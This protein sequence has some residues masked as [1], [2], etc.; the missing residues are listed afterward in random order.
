MIAEK[1]IHLILMLFLSAV[2]IWSAIKP[3]SYSTWWL[4]VTP[5]LF[6]LFI[7]AAIYK[8]FKFTTLVY[9]FIFLQAISVLI[10]GHYTY[11]GMP[12]FDW[13][14]EIFDWNRNHYDRFSHLFQG[15][16]T[17]LIIRELLIRNVLIKQ[18]NWLKVITSMLV[19]SVGA[20]YELIEWWVAVIFGKE[21][22]DFLGTQGD[23]WDAQWDMQLSFLG[24]ILTVGLLSRIHDKFLK[25]DKS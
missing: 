24:A 23:I 25:K 4:E 19:L 13:L 5:L 15:F 11:S 9:F 8:H 21:A 1:R 18:N 10:G 7:L 12:V 17:A 22:E 20:L 3:H 14:K 6:G 2:F 16:G